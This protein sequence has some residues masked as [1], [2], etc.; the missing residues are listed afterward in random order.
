METNLNEKVNSILDT[1]EKKY[2]ASYGERKVNNKGI[3]FDFSSRGYHVRIENIEKQ[4][5]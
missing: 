1:N 3:V 4:N 5:G 2:G